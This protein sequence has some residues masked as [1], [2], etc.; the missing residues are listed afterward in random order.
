MLPIILNKLNVEIWAVKPPFAE[1]AL[2]KAL[3]HP[4]L[5]GHKDLKTTRIYAHV[6]SRGGKGVK[7]PVDDL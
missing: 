1:I 5:R 2:Q 3:S 7:S 4:S 6:F